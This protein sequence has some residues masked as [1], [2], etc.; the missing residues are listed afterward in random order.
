MVRHWNKRFQSLVTAWE[1]Q[2][3]MGKG[4]KSNR[5]VQ[6]IGNSTNCS[7]KTLNKVKRKG[8]TGSAGD[9]AAEVARGGGGVGQRAGDAQREVAQA[10]GKTWVLVL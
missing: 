10:R 5:F 1:R 9:G 4:R 3:G 2:T 6:E 8:F 7:K